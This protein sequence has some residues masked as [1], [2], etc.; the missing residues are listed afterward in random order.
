MYG[1]SSGSGGCGRDVHSDEPL[2]NVRKHETREEFVSVY[3]KPIQYNFTTLEFL[4][5]AGFSPNSSENCVSAQGELLR[6]RSSNAKPI[7]G[8]NL[9]IFFNVWIGGIGYSDSSK[10]N[11]RYITF[12]APDK[13]KGKEIALMTF[14]NG[15]WSEI[16]FDRIGE[17]FTAKVPHFGYFALAEKTVTAAEK[18]TGPAATVKNEDEKKGS[19]D[20][21]IEFIAGLITVLILVAAVT[22]NRYRKK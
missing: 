12:A 4:K 1:S 19:S 5:G 22:A 8:R 9:T 15:S 18:E 6:G 7:D 16:S 11:D 2:A 14:R 13:L 20:I 10:V 21:P 3:K 17:N